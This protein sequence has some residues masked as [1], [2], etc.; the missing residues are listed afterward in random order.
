MTDK[1]TLIVI[2]KTGHVLGVVTR[3]SDPEGK[4][5]PKDVAGEKLLVR[6]AGRPADPH[7]RAG[8]F[9]VPADEIVVEVKDYDPVVVTRPRAFYLDA[10][11]EPVGTSALAPSVSNPGSSNTQIRV[12]AGGATTEKTPVW[13][14]ISSSSDPGNTQ[15]RQGEMNVNE[16]TIDF[17]VLPLDSGVHYVLTLVGG[18]EQ[19][20]DDINV[21]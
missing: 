16:T 17:D 1:M 6:F 2:K 8:Q 3:E 21:P 5:E 13:I 14:Q 9:L 7:F 4:L 12:T 20:V 10:N 18:R 15:V 11:K 19:I